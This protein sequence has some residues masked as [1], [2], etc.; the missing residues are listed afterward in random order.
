MPF[1]RAIEAVVFDMDGLL[2]D[3]EIVVRAA[4]TRAVARVGH[5]LPP[6]VF[7]RSLGCS[8]LQAMAVMM[9]HFGPDFPMDRYLEVEEDEIRQ[10]MAAGV[11]LKAGV[12][13][14]VGHIEARGL[15]F[16]LATSSSRA[17]AE[18]HLT[19][20][21]L[22]DRFAATVGREDVTRHKPNPDPYLEAARRLGLPPTACL[23]L[24]DSHNGVRAAHAAGMMVVMVPDILEPTTEMHGLC[25][26]IA[27]D[28]HEV[29]RLVAAHPR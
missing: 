16:A 7:A 20:H 2:I 6:E 19:R 1:P 18:Q 26:R 28:L 23:A 24:E 8:A 10:A 12:T 9:D 29:H 5:D 17:S 21:G 14:L 22:W 25:V 3:S 27:A 13:E 11:A 15:P 4:V